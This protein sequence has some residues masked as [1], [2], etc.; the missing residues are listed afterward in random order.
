MRELAY[1]ALGS[2]LGDR[3]GYLAFARQ[4][5]AALDGTAIVKAS[6]VEETAPIGPAGQSPYLNQMI[7]ISTELEPHDLLRALQAIEAGA[8]RVRTERWGPRTLDLDIVKYGERRIWDQELVVPHPALE[9]REFWQ[10]ELVELEG[11]GT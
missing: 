8:G 3:E 4:S 5:I 9:D 7:A 10:R 6:A 2:N 11:T 1:V